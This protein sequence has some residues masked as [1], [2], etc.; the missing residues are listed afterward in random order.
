MDTLSA[1]H[2]IPVPDGTDTEIRLEVNG[3]K[4]VVNVE[5][6]DRLSSVL[7]RQL[8]LT[9]AKEGCLEGE[10]GSCTV[11]VDDMPV[12]SCLMLAIQAEG[13]RITTVEGL[14]GPDGELS[15]LQQAFVDSGAIQCGYCTP[16]MVMAAQG[17]LLHNPNPDEPEIR[18]AL[19]GNLC[20]CTGFQTIVEAVKAETAR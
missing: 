3:R 17:L 6:G 14:S 18:Y 4:H 9:G 7:R 8:R 15:S 19:A 2:P 12:N 11:L 16:G 1:P 20:R 5:A 13:R 10:C